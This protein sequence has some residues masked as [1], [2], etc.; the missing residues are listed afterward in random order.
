MFDKIDK[1]FE[2]K[3]KT[4]WELAKFNFVNISITLLQLFLANILP[5]LFDNLTLKLPTLL[6]PIFNP[7]TLFQG[8]S[9]YVIDGVTT[10]GY[11]LPFFLSNLAANIYGYFVNM[12]VTF[13][14][15]TSRKAFAIYV[16][17]FV[18]LMLFTTWVQGF[19]VGKLTQTGFS[20]LSRTIASLVAGF[21]QMCVIYPLE[22]F[23][24]PKI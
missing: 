21:I 18:V 9:K 20:T 23:V 17:V 13:K 24:L 4:V 11:V 2:S 15:K 16:V 1:Y 19:I 14:D 10:W 3:N 8:E 6:R 12:K 5:L 7:K 22:K